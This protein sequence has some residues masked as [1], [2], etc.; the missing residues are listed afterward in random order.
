ME[1]YRMIQLNGK[2]PRNQLKDKQPE[3]GNR[4]LS[5]MLI[6]LNS[7]NE[8]IIQPNS[9]TCGGWTQDPVFSGDSTCVSFVQK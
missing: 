1:I 8:I 2:Q 7:A 3:N 6:I 4:L 9:A 5:S